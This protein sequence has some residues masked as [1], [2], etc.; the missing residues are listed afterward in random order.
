MPE[1]KTHL[2]LELQQA[3]IDKLEIMKAQ[4]R[5]IIYVDEVC[6]TKQTIQS[7][8]YSRKYESITIG[9]QYIY[10]EP[11]YAIASVSAQK[12]VEH[13][14]I[15]PT[16]VKTPD[17]VRFLRDL[18]GGNK[19]QSICVYMDNLH[20]HKSEPVMECMRQLKINYIYNVPYSPDYN[21]IE[22][23]FSKV[24]Q[25]YKKRRLNKL[26]N[27]SKFDSK[28]EIEFAFSQVRIQDIVNCVGR[29]TLL[30]SNLP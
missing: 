1:K 13:L 5:K 28:V 10:T 24:K 7:K 27:K 4:R 23:I 22:A 26:A 12:G 3:V 25:I 11:L 18:R 14:Q 17:F 9:E 21:P 16:P 2:K 29:S 15:Q 20:A 6:F 30:L 8:T 19:Y